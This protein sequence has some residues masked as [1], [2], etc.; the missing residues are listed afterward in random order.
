MGAITDKFYAAALNR[1][2]KPA[3]HGP[4]VRL[5]I[6]G[7]SVL[8]GAGEPQA[9]VTVHRPSFLRRLPLDPSLVFGEAFMKGDMEVTGNILALLEGF[10]RTNMGISSPGGKVARLVS[11]LPISVKRAEKNAQHHYDVGNDFYKLWLDESLTYS[12]AYFDKGT[13]SLG[14]AQTKKRAL[15]LHKLRLERGQTMLD[16]GCGWGSLLFD[17]AQLYGAKAHGVTPA[18]E[19]ASFIRAEAARRGL[20]HLVT[21]DT[22][23]WRNIKG[24]FDRIVSVGMFEHVGVASYPS[25]FRT[26]QE[27]LSP[28]GI[29]V[30]HTIGHRQLGGPNPWINKY[31][32]PGGY[33]PT[34]AEISSAV[35]Q[36]A[37]RMYR[38]ENLRPHYAATLKEWAANFEAARPKIVAMLGE[39]FARMWWLYLKAS[40]AGFRWGELEL[41]QIEIMGK[42][43]K[44]PWSR[45]L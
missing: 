13:E 10:Y 31:I 1:W 38:V 34:L 44:W 43:T 28:Q 33:L 7:T 3:W 20:Q 4:A 23:D 41:F 29:G 24:K 30:L 37:L 26:W 39:E 42:D 32:F 35:S 16:I 6:G 45:E 25:F 2:L 14:E 18:K 15:L 19:Q 8:L 21:V 11:R 40:E 17:A 12:C 22:L 36:T 27:L 9:T 5:V